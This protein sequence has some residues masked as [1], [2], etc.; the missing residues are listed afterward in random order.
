MN[1]PLYK[2]DKNGSLT[3][4]LI[5]TTVL[6]IAASAAIAEESNVAYVDSVHSWGAWELD[7]EPAEKLQC[8]SHLFLYWKKH[9]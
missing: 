4:K 9:F 7:I 6:V 5:L 2:P 8:K 3:A 1:S